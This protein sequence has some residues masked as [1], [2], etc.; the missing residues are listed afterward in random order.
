MHTTCIKIKSILCLGFLFALLGCGGSGGGSNGNG[1]G[2]LTSN[3]SPIANAGQDRFAYTSSGVLSLTGTASDSDGTIVEHQWV[4]TAGPAVVIYGASN[5]TAL[6]TPADETA[7]Y[8]FAYTVT[9]DDGAQQS[10]T[11]SVYVSKILFSDSF[12]NNTSLSS[13]GVINDTATPASW[14][15]VNGQLFQQ[16]R[17]EGFMES[18]HLGTSAYL[19]NSEFSGGTAFR[20]SVD[21]T[22]Q[23]T[24]KGNDVGIMFPFN[25]TDNQNYFRLSMN[26]RYG[27]TR[28]E[29]R[30][31][32]NFRTLA[33]NSIGYMDGQTVNLT[34]EVNQDTIMVMIDGEPL[35]AESDLVISPGTVALYSQEQVS[36]D[37]VV[38]SENS[39]QP[40][41]VVSS[42]LAHSVPLGAADGNTLAVEAVALNQ[43]VG[44]RVVF[45]LDDG[46]ETAST[47]TGKRYAA[48][49]FGVGDGEHEIAAV[50]KDLDDTE[51]SLDINAVVGVGGT[52]IIAVG[53]SITNGSRDENPANN[54]SLDGRIVA[55]QGFEA[56]LNDELTAATGLPQ[57]V[58]NEGIGGDLSSQLDL[59]RIDSIL[60][61]H[62][63]ADT[64]LLL[65]GTN[66]VWANIAVNVYEGHVRAIVNAALVNQVDQV[67]F[68][69]ILP[70]YNAGQATLN[71]RVVIYNTRIEQ[72]V[73]TDTSGIL[74]P[75]PDF[76]TT[77]LNKYSTLY[78][79]DGV[80]PNDAGY[81]AMAVDWNDILT[82][83]Q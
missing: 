69:R 3:L 48:Q 68:A 53:D 79:P 72:I 80:H 35:F 16:T 2:N 66:D 70:F 58:F 50:L 10:D 30:D 39:P 26:S 25:I 20:F 63:G 41:V 32:D 73:E 24:S 7:S 49:F 23:T 4:Q 82:S 33:V 55:T 83:I 19:V 46:S 57:I 13:W 28:L 56:Q 34:V 36:F 51:L 75:G 17:L 76:Y 11:V 65:I 43:P 12:N 1:D 62:P 81:Q 18:Y 74:F 9:D 71:P 67:F 77:F 14:D 59:D 54:D 21:I 8:T 27:F 61:R 31:G 60:E 37:N 45:L 29:K 38:L 5:A 6:F 42:P 40:M 47:A 64:M 52:Y 44:S 22:P 15:V 78:D